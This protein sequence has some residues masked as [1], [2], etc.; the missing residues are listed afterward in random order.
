VIDSIL[1]YLRVED[2]RDALVVVFGLFAQAVFTSRFLVQW[3]VSER[4]GKSVVPAAFWYLSLGGA[5]LLF[6]YGILRGEPLMLL[7]PVPG[8]VIYVRNV[9]LLHRERAGAQDVQ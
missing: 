1:R 2:A 6:V 9:M 4:R 8:A 3:I 7:G 5:G